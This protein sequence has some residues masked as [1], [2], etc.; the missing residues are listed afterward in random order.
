VVEPT[1]TKPAPAEAG[2]KLDRDG[3]TYQARVASN[4]LGR[5]RTT[6][7][8]SRGSGPST[9]FHVDTLDLYSARGRSEFARR[10]SKALGADL[11]AVESDLLAVLVLAEKATAEDLDEAAKAETTVISES[12]R[13][14]ALAFLKRPDFLDQVAQ[15]IDALGYVGEATNARLLYLVAV[16]RKLPDP[17]SAV[18]LS[19]SGAGKSG[20]SEVIERLTPPEDV[21]LV[22]RL[23]PQSLYY[24]EPGTLDHKLIVIEERHGSAEADYSVRVLQSRKK[25]SVMAPIKDP[26]TGN[27]KTKQFEVEARAAFIEA[28]TS[29][30]VNH[31]N[32]T[33]CFELMMD[34]SADQTGRI[35]DRQRLMWTERGHAMRQQAEAITRRHWNAQR[36][37]EPLSVVIPYADKLTF[38]ASWLR[39]RRDNARFLNLIGVSAFLHQYQRERRAGAIVATQ[40][41]YET[42]Y[43]L[44]GEVLVE[45]LS[46][47]KT[48]LRRALE[49]I[50]ALGEKTEGVVSRRDVREQLKEPDST[51][52]RWL[53]D[54]VE[55]EYL[56]VVETGAKAAGKAARYRVEAHGPQ[57]DAQS[58]LMTPDELEARLQ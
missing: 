21:V 48:P 47:L 19:Q 14:E 27:M 25:L 7:K 8:A 41:D 46:D 9:P 36:L 11:E 24:V 49:R 2:I 37:L 15:D 33:R 31:E 56:A 20:I 51:V 40:A 23:T 50:R 29:T 35:H 43:A 53:Q 32:S 38:P 34:E 4:V 44:A 17:I 3:R 10:A 18:I 57:R 6:I 28:T 54:L 45:T 26:Q 22:T 55:L 5:L 58:G 39:T 13:A 16:S 42:A 1:E 52:R 30:D 12:E